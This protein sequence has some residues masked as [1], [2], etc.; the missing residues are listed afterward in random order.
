MIRS[1]L[2]LH[3]RR[4][5]TLIEILVALVITVIGL[6]GIAGMFVANAQGTTYA[7][8]A[9]EASVLAEDQL[10]FMLTTPSANLVS[11]FDQVDEHGVAV[12]SGGFTRVWSVSWDGDLA[13]IAVTVTWREGDAIREMVFRT[14]RSR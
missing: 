1:R 13:R 3:R 8:H 5:F 6:L 14:L 12:A 10:E 9:T 2:R 11:G 4:G 7:R